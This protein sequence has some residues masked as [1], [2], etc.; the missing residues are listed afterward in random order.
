MGVFFGTPLV[1]E[2]SP[3]KLSVD[4]PGRHL[5]PRFKVKSQKLNCTAKN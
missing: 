5:Q 1:I 2:R 3:G 4:A